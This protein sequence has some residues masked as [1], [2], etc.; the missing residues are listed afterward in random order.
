MQDNES[1]AASFA[2]AP[3]AEKSRIDN[4]DIMRGI[5]I[6]GIL[7]MNMPAMAQSLWQFFGGDPRVHGWTS[8]DQWT[9]IT[10][11]IVLEGTQRGML[12]ILFGAGLMLLAARAMKPDGPVAIA[13]LWIRRNMW[14][15]FFGL[16]NALVLLWFGDILLTYGLAALLLFPFRLL[17]ARTLLIIG[18]LYPIFMSVGG[19]TEYVS[20][21]QLIATATVADAK[22]AAGT[23]LTKDEAE[24]QK[25]WNEKLAKVKEG[26]DKETKKLMAEEAKWRSG[27]VGTY[28]AGA[29]GVNFTF[30]GKGLLPLWVAE[31]FFTMLIGLALFKWGVVQGE[32]TKRA[33]LLLMLACYAAGFGMR[34]MWVSEILSFSP[35]PKTGWFT[36]EFSRILVSVGHI[37]MVN[38]AVRTRAGAWLLSPFKAAGRMAFSLY[39]MQSFVTMWVLFAPFG[40]NL[41]GRF[42][43]ADQA[44][45]VIAIAAAQLVFANLWLRMYRM[46]PLEWVW[47]SLSHWKRQ[48]MKR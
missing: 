10:T 29:A 21:T 43:W 6:L 25:K 11:Q 22:V 30:W 17:K 5:A 46:G 45:I 38:W 27:S 12:E 41:Y 18:L 32:R 3:V 16:I 42:A 40:F 19:V 2:L 35:I 14:L 13:D 44:L 34:A 9:W 47:R 28:F 26:P 8:A 23:A 33:Y 1:G 20:R 48:P 24:A 4:I 31:A 15:C 39:L 7:F 36:M 37:A